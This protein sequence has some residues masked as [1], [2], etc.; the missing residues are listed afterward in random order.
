MRT[1]LKG[2]QAQFGT[3]SIY[4][5]H[6]FM[7]AMS[8]AD[9]IAVINE[10]KVIQIGTGDEIYD[11]PLTEFIAQLMG[12]PEINI[13]PGTLE[14]RD[15]KWFFTMDADRIE[16]PIPCDEGMAKV[17]REKKVE[18]VDL[19]LR[20]QY[21]HYAFEPAPEHEK[22]TIYSY[23]SIGNKSVIVAQTLRGEQQYRMI[24]PNGLSL[25]IDAPIYLNFEMDHAMYFDYKTKDFLTRYNEKG[26]REIVEQQKV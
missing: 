20:P 1:E 22:C 12:D 6:D 15:G 10:G 18:K 4:V 2:I 23:E 3:T 7:E 13:T 9:R 8:L 26:Y 21:V 14:E 19:G 16:F 5:T 25:K 11:L 17:F 24:A